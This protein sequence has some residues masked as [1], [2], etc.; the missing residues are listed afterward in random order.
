MA[1][2]EVMQ[3]EGLRSVRAVLEDETIQTEA[4]ALATMDGDIEMTARIPSPLSAIRS[5]LSEQSI[6]KP[7][8]SG[9]GILHLDSSVNGYYVF[10]VPEEEDWILGRGA[11]WASENSIRLS[12]SRQKVLTA[13]YSG[14]GFIYYQIRLSGHGKVVLNADGPVEEIKLKN[15]KLKVDG[16]QV[17]A[18]TEGITYKIKRPTK[19]YLSYWLS[20][21]SRLRVYEGSGSLL[22]SRTPFWNKRLLSAVS[23]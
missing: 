3:V 12:L 6:I 13:L 1:K 19:S 10:D 2:F 15:S 21:E 20:G 4:G 22:I 7:K 11:Y 9:S 18:R 14:E 17:V 5:I 23:Q 8:Y 16:R